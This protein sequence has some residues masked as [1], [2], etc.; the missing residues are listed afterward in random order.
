MSEITSKPQY[1][2]RAVHCDH[3]AEDE[4]VYEA[5]RRAT[6][7]LTRAWDRLR[8][9]DR[10]GIKFNQDFRIERSPRFKG[11][12]QQLVSDKVAWAVVRL[13]REET[14]AELFYTD[15]TAFK[16][17]DDPDPL[18]TT[19]L[20]PL[21][22]TLDVP[23]VN[24]DRPP[25]TVYPVP[26]G[27]QMFG[28]YLLPAEIMEADALVDVQK[29]KNHRFMGITLTLKNLFGLVPREPH[30]RSRQYFHHLV[31]M[32]YMLAD[33]GR[34]F[35]PA[36]NV[37][38]AL[39]G[40]AG[41]EW[42]DGEGLGRVVDALVAGDHPVATDAVGAYLMGHD[43]QADWPEE[44]FRR[45]RNAI[46]VAA[47]GGYGTV[48]LDEIDVESEIDP[49]PAGTFFTDYNDTMERMV[50]WR[51]TTC[52]QALYYRDNVESFVDKY[53]HRYILL[54][55]YEVKWHGESSILDVSRRKLAGDKPNQAMWFK[56]VDP[57]EAEGEHY[58]V[59][60][61]TLEDLE[62]KGL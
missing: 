21:M 46:L 38:D 43:P 34:L 39:T 1:R 27:G 57:D 60:E 23:Y 28:Q 20:A 24:G 18:D 59:Y 44:P 37:I 12:R 7:P 19:Q 29:M 22:E 52:E 32:P 14:D 58:E 48:D 50:S 15:I 41:M 30:G 35:D 16:R 25:H 3:Q 45:D 31:R 56:Y 42:G 26:G 53:A 36:L 2:V 55:D 10:I 9:A 49:Q 54:Q 33:I 47:N 11:M 5:L 62:A 6:M 13:L 51:R 4:A 61:E 8:S 40:Q 17:T